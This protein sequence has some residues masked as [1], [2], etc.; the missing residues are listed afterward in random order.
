MKNLASPKSTS[1]LILKRHLLALAV[2]TGLGLGGTVQAANFD[3]TVMQDQGDGTDPTNTGTLSWAIRQANATAGTD[4]ITLKTDVVVQGV[5][6]S[7]ID[8]DLTLQ[9]DGSPRSISG[10]NTYRPLFIKSGTVKIKNLTLKDGKAKGGDSYHGG[11]GAGLGGALFVYQ[12]NVSLEGVDFVNNQA[13]GGSGG[14][15]A[16]DATGNS[17]YGAGG[18]GMLGNASLLGGGGLFASANANVGGYGGNGK[19]SGGLSA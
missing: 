1:H 10:S 16:I 19:Y 13:I 4:T 12:G 11:G 9:N 2:S 5:M 15:A 6:K 8:S 18:G 3:V 14:V 7:L 17:H